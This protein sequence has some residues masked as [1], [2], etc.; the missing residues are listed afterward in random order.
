MEQSTSKKEETR[1]KVYCKT[2]DFYKLRRG[3]VVFMSATH[4]CKAVKK[5]YNTSRGNLIEYG[6]AQI[7]NVN[8]DCNMW[9][10]K[11]P[12]NIF[13]LVSRIICGGR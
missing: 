12:R 2:C 13:G 3:D 10:E 5:E 1:K 6:D 8:N 9:K 11:K 7:I 4:D